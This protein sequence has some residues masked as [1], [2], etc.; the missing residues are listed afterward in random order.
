MF[1]HSVL[2]RNP[3][4]VPCYKIRIFIRFLLQ[5][6]TPIL[7]PLAPAPSQSTPHCSHTFPTGHCPYPVSPPFTSPHFLPYWLLPEPG[8]VHGDHASPTHLPYLH[9]I[10]HFHYPHRHFANDGKSPSGQIAFG[11]IVLR[12]IASGETALGNPSPGKLSLEILSLGKSIL[13]PSDATF[14]NQLN[15]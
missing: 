15:S 8:T 11:K 10:S 7:T 1:C 14:G 3:V 12:E 9:S 4:V 6:G 2:N 5:S 13:G